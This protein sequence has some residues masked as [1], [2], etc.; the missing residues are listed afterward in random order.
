MNKTTIEIPLVGGLGNQLFVLSFGVFVAKFLNVN[1]RLIQTFSSKGNQTHGNKVADQVAMDGL[2][3][4]LVNQTSLSR[5]LSSIG[6]FLS[7]F[8]GIRGKAIFGKTYLS[9]AEFLALLDKSQQGFRKGTYQIHGYF[10]EPKYLEHIQEYGYLNH[11]IA[12]SPSA[13]FKEALTRAGSSRTVGMHVRRGDTLTIPDHGV[14]SIDYYKSALL[15]LTE[16]ELR[17]PILV[18]CDEPELLKKEFSELAKFADLEF[19]SP[20]EDSSPIESIIL[21]SLCSTLIVSN[22]TFSWWAASVG[23]TSRR[24]I[25]PD[26]WSPS[27]KRAIPPAKSRVWE[28]IAPVWR[29]NDG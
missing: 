22:S 18:F 6:R 24:V 25:C 7:K 21:M 19:V 28:L 1:V 8:S 12:V 4:D 15:L 26:A 17:R 29:I 16:E 3:V 5:I 13:W 11:L 20:P 2:P 10:Q 27:G 14:L 9:E 23:E